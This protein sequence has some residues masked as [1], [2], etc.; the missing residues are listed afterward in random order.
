ML[1]RYAFRIVTYVPTEIV[2]LLHVQ[3]T[4][5]NRSLNK[6]QSLPACSP[7]SRQNHDPGYDSLGVWEHHQPTI[8]PRPALLRPCRSGRP[9]Q[10]RSCLSIACKR[11][12]V[13][14]LTFVLNVIFRQPVWKLIRATENA[15]NWEYLCLGKS[16]Q[17]LTQ[18]ERENAVFGSIWLVLLIGLFIVAVFT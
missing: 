17:P 10:S 7:S 1:I 9:Q 16:K 14:R 3:L 8:R 5:I 13:N 15:V 18:Q 4:I 11:R 2:T 12:R 6:P